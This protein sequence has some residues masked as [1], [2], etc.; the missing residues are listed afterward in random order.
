MIHESIH[1]Q[2]N[3]LKFWNS[4]PNHVIGAESVNNSFIKL[5][6]NE[7]LRYDYGSPLS[8]MSSYR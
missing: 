1:L 6:D 7:E 4:L 5:W 8:E 2:L 3:R